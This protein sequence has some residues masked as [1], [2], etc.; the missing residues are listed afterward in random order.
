[1]HL[2]KFLKHSYL[3]PFWLHGLPILIFY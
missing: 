3:L 2:L 1:V